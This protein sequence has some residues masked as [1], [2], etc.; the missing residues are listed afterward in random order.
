M[1][2]VDAI[3]VIGSALTIIGF[4][5]S[6][7][8]DNPPKGAKIRI[9]A[10]LSG[11]DD[12]QAV[13]MPHLKAHCMYRSAERNQDGQIARAFAWDKANNYLGQARG[14]HL[15]E[16]DTADLIID[17]HSPSTRAELVSIVAA[18]DAVC[19]A[20]VTVS[21][22]DDTRGGAWTGD[23]GYHCGQSWY[24]QIET[25]GYLSE[26]STID[27][28]PKCTWLDEDHS[29]GIKSA[30]M[31]F[32]TSAYGKKVVETMEN[33]K[34]CDYTLWKRDSGPISGAYSL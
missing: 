16:G 34:A 25:A 23:I 8:P 15:E 13:S 22:N 21:M 1:G 19:I 3:G 7:I 17:Q 20:W 12:P 33:A 31:K 2:V 5:Q 18:K 24:E 27:Y 29:Y 28:V 6:N 4:L 14:A 30:A 26:N 11:D 32:N 10:G 9:K